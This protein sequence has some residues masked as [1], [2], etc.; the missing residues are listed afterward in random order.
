M[1]LHRGE[2]ARTHH[3]SHYRNNGDQHRYRGID[4]WRY[5][6]NDRDHRHWDPY[7]NRY[8]H[9]SC[10][11]HSG[12]DQDRYRSGWDQDRYRY[13]SYGQYSYRWDCCRH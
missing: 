2:S 9:H 5:R 11:R 7:Q 6:F 4:L 8:R 13:G 12:W 1:A 10:N 3:P